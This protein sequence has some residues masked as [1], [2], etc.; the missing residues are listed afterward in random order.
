MVQSF[1]H[2]LQVLRPKLFVPSFAT[3]DACISILLLTFMCTVMLESPHFVYWIL[4][5]FTSSI[6]GCFLS[7]P[8][9]VFFWLA[10]C[11]IMCDL[12]CIS[13]FARESSI[14][15]YGCHFYISIAGS[16]HSV[17][18]LVLNQIRL[19]WKSVD[20]DELVFPPHWGTSSVLFVFLGC[21][22][23]L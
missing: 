22:F 6:L 4:G 15:R 2:E 7:E 11:S 14:F 19:S 21:W 16:P 12:F 10:C 18:K 17:G 5:L 23:Q 1:H 9:D 13:G 8:L 3:I 20:W